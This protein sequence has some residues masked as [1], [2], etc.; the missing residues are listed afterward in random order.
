MT[1]NEPEME[2]KYGY[3]GGPWDRGFADFWY[4][5]PRDPHYWPEGTYK[6]ERVEAADMTQEELSAYHLAY[7][8]AEQSGDQ[9]D[10]G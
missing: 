5:R 3:H 1:V 8:L 2:K 7:T 10:W 9:K 6:G 4:H